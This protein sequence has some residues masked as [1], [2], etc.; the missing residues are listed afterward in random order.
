MY[1]VLRDYKAVAEHPPIKGITQDECETE[2]KMKEDK[3]DEFMSTKISEF[4]DRGIT[5][6]DIRIKV[7]PK[8]KKYFRYQSKTD[9]KQSNCICKEVKKNIYVS[10]DLK[11]LIDKTFFQTDDGRYTNWPTC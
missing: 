6:K 1:A 5:D 8:S 2:C 4:L 7:V 9:G 3:L 11:K 10:P